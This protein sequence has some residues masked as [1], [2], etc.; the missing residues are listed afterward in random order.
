VLECIKKRRPNFLWVK[1]LSSPLL[2]ETFMKESFQYVSTGKP[3][4]RLELKSCFPVA[5]IFKRDTYIITFLLLHF[6]EKIYYS[7]RITV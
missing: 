7:S 3:E 5:Y 1:N 6:Y 4:I 2:L